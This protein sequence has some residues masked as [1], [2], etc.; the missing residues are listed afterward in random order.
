MIIL[1]FIFQPFSHHPYEGITMQ[2]DQNPN[3]LLTYKMI[4]E[5][6]GLNSKMVRKLVEAGKFPA[7][8]RPS[9]SKWSV[10][11]RRA[12][13]LEWLKDQQVTLPDAASSVSQVSR[14]LRRRDSMT[15]DLAPTPLL[16]EIIPI[17][18]PLDLLLN[19][20]RDYEHHP[21]STTNE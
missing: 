17:G 18:S 12:E 4:E 19:I 13:L 2:P 6:F 7:S 9:V 5:E 11:W 10:R 16:T 20:H 3:R 8:Y 15:A 14:T 1:A 21:E